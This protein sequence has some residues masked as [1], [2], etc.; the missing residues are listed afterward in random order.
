MGFVS[1]L[2]V[3]A[4]YG[5][6]LLSLVYFVHKVLW[7]IR[8]RRLQ[9]SLAHRAL[10]KLREQAETS[11]I[12]FEQGADV[13]W[14]EVAGEQ[15]KSP[16][17][18]VK[19]VESRLDAMS[20]EVQRSVTSIAEAFVASLDPNPDTP[21]ERFRRV[22]RVP[23]LYGAPRDVHIDLAFPLVRVPNPPDETLYSLEVRSR[24]KAAPRVLAFLLGAADVFYG[25]RHVVRIS[26]NA[27]VPLAVLM[28]RMSLIAL[29]L[30]ALMVDLFFGARKQLIAWSERQVAEGLRVPWDGTI[31]DWLN[32]NLATLLGLGLWLGAYGALYLSIFAVLHWRS[33]RNLRKLR[34]MEAGRESVLG[35]L[36][37][38]HRV[39]LHDWAE[40]YA[41]GLDDAAEIGA[42]QAQML[43]ERTVHRLRRRLASPQLLRE[44][45]KM[46]GAFFALL[47][48]SSKSLLDS[49]TEH[50]HSFWHA[51]WPRKKEMGYHVTLAKYREAWQQLETARQALRGRNPDPAQA[52]ALWTTMVRLAR[53]FPEVVPERVATWLGEAHATTLRHIVERTERDLKEL[54]GRLD[55]LAHGMTETFGAVAPVVESR[56]EL[57]SEALEHDI[58]EHIATVLRV[59]EEARVE[60]MAFEI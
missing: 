11:V 46:A 8:F 25:A 2:L 58:A 17:L 30:L 29:V 44:A 19:R 22:L 18:Y 54:D 32:E 12:R 28:R 57:T 7:F 52:Q 49:A 15:D 31:G 13:S 50:Q 37:A 3:V 27:R 56:V 34:R 35:E 20:K 53:M 55:D 38:K 14:T 16:L 4:F 51:I 6:M 36:E 59:R 33:H 41:Y 42:K 10:G 21:E 1:T 26:Q 45:D 24:Y 43:I 9:E 23:R 48:E 40:D 47:P 39:E 60:A 5:V